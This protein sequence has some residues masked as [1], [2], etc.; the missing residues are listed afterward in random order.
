MF[1][2]GGQYVRRGVGRSAGTT[3]IRLAGLSRIGDA[4]F[5]V[6]VYLVSGS[7]GPFQRP[8]P[9]EQHLRTTVRTPST[10]LCAIMVAHVFLADVNVRRYYCQR[11]LPMPKPTC[12]NLQLRR[13]REVAR[14]PCTILVY[15]SGPEAK[16]SR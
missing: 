2:R 5:S 11:Y 10:F 15:L 1:F 9:N 6:L 13:F 12:N 14:S 7:V 4:L 8:R 3:S 16:Y